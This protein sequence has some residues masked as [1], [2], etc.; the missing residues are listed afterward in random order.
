VT[1]VEVLVAWSALPAYTAVM[2]R[3][4]NETAFVAQ[5][6]TPPA[7][8]CA[9]QLGMALLPS[10]NATAPVGVP[11]AD[12]TVAVKVTG[13]PV[14]VAASLVMSAVDVASALTVWLR[15]LLVLALKLASLE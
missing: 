12:V 9:P 11:V 7:K 6:A 4:P 10:M 8:V 14:T 3:V 15:V 5:V 13:S 2:D 1:G